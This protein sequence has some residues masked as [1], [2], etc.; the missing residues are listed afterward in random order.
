MVAQLAP[1]AQ[2][3]RLHAGAAVARV[4]PEESPRVSTVI[5]GATRVEQVRENMTALDVVDKL[6]PDVLTRVDAIVEA[7]AG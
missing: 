1:I 4:V 3:S 7:H 5:T 2:R 6:T